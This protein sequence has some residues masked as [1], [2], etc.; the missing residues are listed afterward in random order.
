MNIA[1]VA[2]A[3]VFACA[4]LLAVLGPAL[5]LYWLQVWL[6]RRVAHDA[7]APVLEADKAHRRD[8]PALVGGI[9]RLLYVVAILAGAPEL[10][11]VW[12]ALKVA[13]GWKA[14]SDGRDISWT[15]E[16]GSSKSVTVMGRHEFNIFL[17]GSGLSLLSAGAASY[18][19]RWYLAGDTVNAWLAVV[20]AVVVPLA[21]MLWAR[22]RCRKLGGSAA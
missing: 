4:A 13:G 7:K 10:V 21:I 14:W 6:W 16:D 20:A 5:Q 19:A 1:P 8:L 9:E 15:T 22:L 17:I 18:A 12:L 2:P 11:A 3:P